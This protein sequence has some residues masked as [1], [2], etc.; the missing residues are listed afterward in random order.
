M[1][2]DKSGAHGDLRHAH[3]HQWLQCAPESKQNGR[4][5]GDA[6]EAT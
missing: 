2:V 5:G 4:L 6:A 1:A 3:R